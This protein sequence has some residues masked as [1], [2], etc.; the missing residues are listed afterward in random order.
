MMPLP[1]DPYIV[2]VI[3]MVIIALVSV[4]ANVMKIWKMG[5]KSPSVEELLKQH[6]L[7]VEHERDVAALRADF[8]GRCAELKIENSEQWKVVNAER[9]TIRRN[10][11]DIN[12]ALGQIE[13]KL[14][15]IRGAAR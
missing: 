3:L 13:G 8:L 1:E 4:T 7:K 2:M 15:M 5:K 12:R 9:A 10:M 11:E 14:D 6:V